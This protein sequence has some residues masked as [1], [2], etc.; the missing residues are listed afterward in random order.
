MNWP[1]K[2]RKEQLPPFIESAIKGF[3]IWRVL[4]P[5][6]NISQYTH[7][8]EKWLRHQWAVINRGCKKGLYIEIIDQSYIRLTRV[9]DCIEMHCLRTGTDG[10]LDLVLTDNRTD[11]TAPTPRELMSRSSPLSWLMPGTKLNIECYAGDLPIYYLPIRQNII[12]RASNEC[13]P[14]CYIPSEQFYEQDN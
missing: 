11:K 8:S 12:T 9:S 5:S 6:K 7:D 4:N 1:F 10:D 13:P 2:K 14:I 3:R